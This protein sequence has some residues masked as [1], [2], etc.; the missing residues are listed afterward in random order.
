MSLGQRLPR[1]SAVP[2]GRDG[3]PGSAIEGWAKSQLQ[4]SAYR[5]VRRTT[6]QYHDGILTLRGCV[7]SF[8]HKQIAQS[9]L[10]DLQADVCID[11]RLEVP[12]PT[13]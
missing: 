12:M 3:E 5:T 13:S 7:P 4:R 2:G 1:P 11:N 9:L 6:C 10:R 8:F